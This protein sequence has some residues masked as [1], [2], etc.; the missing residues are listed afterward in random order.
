MSGSYEKQDGTTSDDFHVGGPQGPLIKN[1][2]GVIEFRNAGDS[3]YAEVKFS[4][5]KNADANSAVTVAMFNTRLRVMG[6]FDAGTT[7]NNSATLGYKL[8]VGQG[9]DFLYGDLGFDNG[10]NDGTPLVRV[11]IVAGMLI[12]TSSAVSTYFTLQANT[13]YVWT[14]STYQLA[15][16]TGTT[17]GTVAAGNDS[18]ITGSIQSSTLTTD[19]DVLMRISGVPSRMPLG[20]GLT[21]GANT[22][23]VD[24]TT[25]ADRAY[26]DATVGGLLYKHSCRAVAT[27]N[28]SSLSGTTT[29]DD[30]SLVAGNRVLL[31]AQSDATKNGPWNV[32][33]GAWTRADST[34]LQASAAFPI[35]E[36]TAYHDTVWYITTND[37]ITQGSTSISISQA[38]LTVT[39]SGITDATTAGKAL[40][41]A[42]DAAAQRTSLG[43]GGAAVLSVGTTAGTV[44]AGDDS[45]ITGAIQASTLTTNG[46]LLVRA[47][48]VPARLGVGTE[49]SLL[50]VVGG[51]PA[52]S[53]G[54][55]ITDPRTLAGFSIGNAL[56]RSTVAAV[57]AAV[58]TGWTILLIGRR[59]PYS[60]S[61]AFAGL[62]SYGDLTHGFSLGFY[63]NVTLSNA[64]AIQMRM[65][66]YNINGAGGSTTASLGASLPVPGASGANFA[67]AVEVRASTIACYCNGSTTGTVTKTGTYAPMITTTA[68]YIGSRFNDSPANVVSL[69][70]IVVIQQAL[71]DST[72]QSL[73]TSGLSAMTFQTALSSTNRS[74]TKFCWVGADGGRDVRIGYGPMTLNT[75]LSGSFAVP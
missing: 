6:T 32:A 28:V 33:S 45:R 30:V 25:I 41:T 74:N 12:V 15:V 43:L 19:G 9:G 63:G 56:T 54:T 20:S 31:T 57:D 47:S 5:S 16:P 50:T 73:T 11:P 39:S 13:A 24:T 26:V 14:G 35:T 42:A 60:G 17:S 55:R 52:W 69:T 3:A 37:P 27:S 2:S 67:L 22:L 1:S 40:L 75:L 51:A 29:I 71:G 64:D 68:M 36:G 70:E 58:D 7:H 8:C 59:L 72:L 53:V 44:A 38:S 62:F 66:G 4:P 49:G 10:L 65:A 18:R 34:D 46:D 48:G 21:T 61:N 23:A